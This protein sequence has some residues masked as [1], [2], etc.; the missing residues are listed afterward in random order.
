[1]R[2]EGNTTRKVTLDML[3]EGNRWLAARI[4]GWM[5]YIEY[6][7]SLV[8]FSWR[9]RTGQIDM[10]QVWGFTILLLLVLV[11]LLR[12]GREGSVFF[13]SS[14]LS[15]FSSVFSLPHSKSLPFPFILAFHFIY[16]FFLS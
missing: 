12:L 4:H 9:D 5:D 3:I 7:I 16:L 14:L 6:C 11:L 13:T 10:Q 2:N 8:C 1:M 15:C